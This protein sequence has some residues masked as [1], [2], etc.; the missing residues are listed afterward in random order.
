MFFNKNIK[1]SF[2]I[3]GG[4]KCGTSSLYHYLN[5]HP[6][7]LPCQNKEP[8]FFSAKNPIRILT[9]L[10]KYAALFPEK[11]YHGPIEA[12]WLDLGKDEKMVASKLYK[13]KKEDEHYITGEASANT[14]FTGK[15]SI[16]K[17]ILPN[18]KLI[19]LVRQPAARFY[20]HYKMFERLTRE[21]RKEFK[22]PELESFIDQEIKNYGM[23]QTTKIL[24]KGVYTDYLPKWKKSFGAE[25]L[26]V[27]ATHELESSGKIVMEQLI[28]YLGLKSFDFGESLKKR[29]NQAKASNMPVHIQQKLD[30]FYQAST[31]RLKEEFGVDLF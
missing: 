9:G 7:V 27:I 12:D 1:P 2:F 25:K 13:T 16:V 14:F 17:A 22:L 20:S 4:I 21:G 23:G 29:H 30:S 15:P 6:Q 11:N 18:V 26:K 31:M 28:E 5:E 24:H 19:M 10:K 3:I 8:R